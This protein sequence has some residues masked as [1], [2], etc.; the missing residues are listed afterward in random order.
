MVKYVSRDVVEV[1]E[2]LLEAAKAGELLGLAYIVKIGPADNRAGMA[3]VFKREPAK[4]L[5]A[6]FQLERYLASTGPFAKG[7][8]P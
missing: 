8:S 5:Q 7:Y 6:T 4:A 2:D 3:G 1:L